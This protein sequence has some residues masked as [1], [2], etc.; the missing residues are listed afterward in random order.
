MPR[1]VIVN[2]RT[3]TPNLVELAQRKL[4]DI[5]DIPDNYRSRLW[6]TTKV[7]REVKLT[8][9]TDHF[10]GIMCLHFGIKKDDIILHAINLLWSEVVHSVD[11]ERLKLY[12]DHVEAVRF[13]KLQKKELSINRRAAGLKEGMK[14]WHNDN[15]SAH[16]RAYGNCT[17]WNLKKKAK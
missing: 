12:E 3:A 9:E 13:E 2:R 14:Q 5:P 11:T 6:S 16:V 10:L 8:E 17:T 15:P 4:E 1:G 7:F